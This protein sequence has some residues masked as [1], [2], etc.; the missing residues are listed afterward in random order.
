MLP[1]HISYEP[2]RVAEP[3]SLAL[4]APTRNDS[5]GY[6]GASL[7]DRR[8][9]FHTS[10]AVPKAQ[11]AALRGIYCERNAFVFV[12]KYGVSCL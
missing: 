5:L 1:R 10:S 8:S 3:C 7:R 4:A 6:N 9:I 2:A 12:T 11:S